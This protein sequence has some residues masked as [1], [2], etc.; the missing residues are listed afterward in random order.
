MDDSNANYAGKQSVKET[1]GTII[2]DLEND[3][4]FQNN[5]Y[6]IKA[7]GYKVY[8]RIGAKTQGKINYSMISEIIVK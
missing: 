1:E 2:F 8:F 4:A 5:L 6:K 3:A 7:N